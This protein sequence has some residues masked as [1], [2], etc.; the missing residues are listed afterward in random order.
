V[1]PYDLHKSVYISCD[2]HVKN[3]I[4]EKTMRILRRDDKKENRERKKG[5][6]SILKYEALPQSTD[7]CSHEP[8]AAV[9]S[10]INQTGGTVHLYTNVGWV[11]PE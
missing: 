3:H 7:G 4:A 8:A 2:I 1:S 9:L 11:A 10:D 6:S 5:K